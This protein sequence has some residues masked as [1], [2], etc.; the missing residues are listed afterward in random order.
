[1]LL[2]LNPVRRGRDVN[3]RSFAGLME[4]YEQNYLR[5]RNLAP[6]LKVAD[7]MISSVPGHQDLYLS[8]IL[9]CRYTTMLRL[10]YQFEDDGDLLFEPD[11]HLKVYHDARVI[12]VQQFT[13]RAHGPLY[14]ADMI[15]QKWMMNRFL[16]KWLGYCLHQGH[17]FQPM[18]HLKA[19]NT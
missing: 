18:Q 3:A 15:E 8:I 13:S 11:L 17:Y 9:R 12:E 14:V 7:E 10:T 6:D 4:L 5:L 2:D 1:M 16:F 19:G